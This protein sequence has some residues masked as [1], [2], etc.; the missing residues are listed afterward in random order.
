MVLEYV[1]ENEVGGK[2]EQYA[3]NHSCSHNVTVEVAFPVGRLYDE[4]YHSGNH[5]KEEIDGLYEKK[6]GIRI[7]YLFPDYAE[8]PGQHSE[9]YGGRDAGRE[10][11]YPPPVLQPQV[12]YQQE[13]E[14]ENREIGACGERENENQDSKPR[15]HNVPS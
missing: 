10:Q 1:V 7:I 8:K 11:E 14:S 12:D 15:R 2:G 3:R 5:R 13:I 4:R 6:E 9:K